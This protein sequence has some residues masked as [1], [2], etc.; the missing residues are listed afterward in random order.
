MLLCNDSEVAA[1]LALLTKSFKGSGYSDMQLQAISKH[2]RRLTYRE[3]ERVIE[4]FAIM[5]HAIPAPIKIFEQC[6]EIIK[7]RN[8]GPMAV[9]EPKRE[10]DCLHCYET[11]L[12]FV[13]A[14]GAVT[15]ARCRCKHGI[16]CDEPIPQASLKMQL[17]KFPLEKFQPTTNELRNKDMSQWPTLMWWREVKQ[18]ARD[19][20]AAQITG[21]KQPEGET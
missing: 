19:F 8:A 2:F 9:E 10:P 7:R 20:W 4:G 17:F 3:G 12:C 16:A 18:V 11:G 21:D 5:G 1:L 14:Q 15:L 6:N 13:N